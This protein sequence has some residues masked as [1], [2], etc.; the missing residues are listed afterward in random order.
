MCAGNLV[1]SA[2]VLEGRGSNIYHPLV[3]LEGSG[4]A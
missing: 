2:P 4:T 3:L 1:P